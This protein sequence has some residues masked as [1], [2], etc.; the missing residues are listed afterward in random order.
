MS[1]II[2]NE[3]LKTILSCEYQL[4]TTNLCSSR[5][6]LM[7]MSFDNYH[8]ASDVTID[9]K[10]ITD[11]NELQDRL[12]KKINLGYALRLCEDW[13]RYNGFYII[14]DINIF[15]ILDK[16]LNVLYKEEVKSDYDVIENFKLFL[17]YEYLLKNIEYLKGLNNA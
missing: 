10:V 15:Y 17:P 9:Y 2:S 8:I 13:C 4:E 6:D 1:K 7:I 16:S 11:D 14:N 5:S 3:L 12:D